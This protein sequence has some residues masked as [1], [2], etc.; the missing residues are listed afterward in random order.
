MDTELVE[1]RDFLAQH[2][3]FD[4]LPQPVLDRLVSRLEVRYV[5]RGT[6]I[7]GVGQP[8]DVMYVLR[9]GAVDI[10]DRDGDLVERSESGTSFGMSA[11]LQGT[12]SSYE[13]TAIEDS[14]VLAVPAPVFLD[15]CREQPTVKQ[16]FDRR[17][18]QRARQAHAATEVSE[19]GSSGLRTSARE[20]VTRAPETA[21]AG[22]SIREAAETMRL[23]GVSSL[24][25]MEDSRLVGI[26]TD[27]DLRNRVLAE[28]LD[29]G[30]RV[31]TVMTA[32]PVTGSADDLAFE[33]LLEMV[34]RNIHH[35]PIVDAGPAGR[36]RDEHRP[37]AA[38]ARQPR[39]PRRRPRA[40]GR[41]ASGVAAARPGGCRASSSSSPSRT[42]R[43]T[44]SAA[45]S[46]P[47][48]RRRAATARRSPMPTSAPR[49]CPTAGWRS[50]RGPGSSRRWPPT[51]TTP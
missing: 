6:L 51:R 27:R 15:L 8:T 31:A 30:D 43:P 10:R 37:P 3:P 47:W 50:A 12:T 39:L 33:L 19:R 41:R 32:D 36:R 49:R 14:L 26:V 11:L 2:A 42:P 21:S 7:L 18:R 25:L 29:P 34:G 13:F 1:I 5:R 28:G 24:L 46:P 48:G 23:R 9:S 44:T 45:S 35:L 20:L 4:A 40:A 22:V 38:R 17:H 16:F